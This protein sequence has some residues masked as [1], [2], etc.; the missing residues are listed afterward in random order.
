MRPAITERLRRRV[1]RAA[2]A[3]RNERGAAAVEFALIL[4]IVAALTFGLIDGSLT[5]FRWTAI[6]QASRAGART[7]SEMGT[8]QLADYKTLQAVDELLRNVN[9]QDI[10]RVVIYNADDG[11]D[12]TPM[13]NPPPAAC[14]TSAAGVAD[15]CNVYTAADLGRTQEEYAAAGRFGT[16]N[17][18][19]RDDEDDAD[20]VDYV[21]VYVRATVKT[22]TKMLGADRMVSEFTV[23]R[24]EPRP[25]PYP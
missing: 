3:P 12:T 9:P 24:L 17:P 1:R 11:R 14:L 6:S 7:V 16:W 10:D 13:D 5:F 4:P 25:T 8:N 20:G 15:T 2:Q 21:G 19:T 23:V 22:P 18:L